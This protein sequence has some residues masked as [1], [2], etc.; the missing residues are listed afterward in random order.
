MKPVS[1]RLGIPEVFSENGLVF[2]PKVCDALIDRIKT[3]ELNYSISR[4][5]G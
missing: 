3:C 1:D 2:L 4:I 5:A